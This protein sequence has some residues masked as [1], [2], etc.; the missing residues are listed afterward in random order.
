MLPALTTLRLAS[1]LDRVAFTSEDGMLKRFL[2]IGP[3]L[4]AAML[5]AV[6]ASAAPIVDPIVRVRGGGASIPIFG[7]PFKFPDEPFTFPVDPDGEGSDDCTSGPSPLPDPGF[8]VSCGF[9]NLTGETISRLTF[10]FSVATD[11]ETFFLQDIDDLFENQRL[12]P[13]GAGFFGGGIPTGF[14]DEIEGCSGG[15]FIV[16]LVGFEAG[17]EIQMT[18]TQVPEPG[19]LLLLATGLAAAIAASGRRIT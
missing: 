6:S 12:R 11:P 8:T 19:A 15:E 14:C 2:W 16:D 1:R 13:F 18:A 4:A 3:W 7:L 5:L 17:T 9:Q 10:S